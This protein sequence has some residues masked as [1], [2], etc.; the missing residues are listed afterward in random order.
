MA[1][2]N[3][4]NHSRLLPIYHFVGYPAVLFAF[5]ISIVE[6]FNSL[7][8]DWYGILKAAAGVSL[9]IAMAILIWEARHFGLRAQDRAIRAEEN[10]RH[11]IATGKPLDSRLG[12]RQI[13]ALRFAGDDEFVALAK[14]AVEENMSAK[15]IKLA[16]KNWRADH[17]RV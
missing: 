5:T 17:H 16:I 1:E 2:Q 14:K 10:F 7:N 9:M 12:L 11:F 3:F 13:V 6:F 15:E 8:G 4:K